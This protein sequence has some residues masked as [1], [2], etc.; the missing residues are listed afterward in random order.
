[1]S[2]WLSLRFDLLDDQL[3][4]AERRP[5]GRVD[6]LELRLPPDGGAPEVEA[7]LTGAE[8]LGQRL[9]GV[10]GTWMAALSARLRPCCAPAG[11]ARVDAALVAEVQP[12]VQL[13]VPLRDLPHV[14]GLE[15][16]LAHQVVEPMPGAGDARE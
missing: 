4:D 8:A 5:I 11:P 7:V 16:W 12:L 6:D 2:T 15:R 9:G 10:V 1:M 13:S 3:V 14:A